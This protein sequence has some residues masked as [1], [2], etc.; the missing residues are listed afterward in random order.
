MSY[1]RLIVSWDGH[2]EVNNGTDYSAIFID[3]NSLDGLTSQSV[4]AGR[5]GNT[6]LHVRVQPDGLTF[7]V[8]I[9]LEGGLTQVKLDQLKAWFNPKRGERW[10]VAQ[11]QYGSGASERILCACNSLRAQ[12]TT[13]FVAEMRA[14][15]G[16]WQ[17]V[18]ADTDSQDVGGGGGEV[19][20]WTLDN[21]GTDD[22][23][24]VVTVTASAAKDDANNYTKRRWI[25]VANRSE[26]ELDDPDSDGYPVMLAD[27]GALTITPGDHV[28]VY[29]GG[30]DLRRWI[31]AS[32]RVWVNLHLRPRKIATLAANIDDTDIA[33]AVNNTEGFDRD[34][35]YDSGFFKIDDETIQYS[36][37][38]RFDAGT[39]TRGARG[40]VAA[41]HT[42]GATIYWVEHDYLYLLYDY[43]TPPDPPL[44]D[45]FEPLIDMDASSNDEHQWA[46]E[47]YNPTG[48]RRSRGWQRR[49]TEAGLADDYVRQYA[50]TGEAV[51]ENAAPAA[52]KPGLNDAVM[53]FLVP[54]AGPLEL[55]QDVG[56][57]MMLRAFVQD[58]EGYET[59]LF[60]QPYTATPLTAD[61]HALADNVRQ[62]RLQGRIA[63][64]VGDLTLDGDVDSRTSNTAPTH[65]F[66]RFEL[67]QQTAVYG[68]LAHHAVS[69]GGTAQVVI[70]RNTTEE[71]LGDVPDI[72]QGLVGL[73]ATLPDTTPDWVIYTLF[74]GIPIFLAAGIYWLRLDDAT[75]YSYR[76]PRA[77]ARSYIGFVNE[78]DPEDLGFTIQPTSNG[79][80]AILSL[81]TDPQTDAPFGAGG[82]VRVAN[83]VAPLDST[84]SPKIDVGAEADVYLVDEEWA[85]NTSQEYLQLFFPLSV[86]EALEIDTERRLI[87]DLETGQL[88]PWARV[89]SSARWPHLEPGVND[90]EW[91]GTGVIGLDVDTTWN[92]LRL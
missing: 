67:D 58:R 73:D 39:L 62:V 49:S 28:R 2:T 44:A 79:I 15:T 72:T 68:V 20:A 76:T 38:G 6:P 5:V 34:N 10:L 57:E 48:S 81:E 31:D 23:P 56:L 78:T 86:G 63:A 51:F 36:G 27:L 70:Y 80:F 47:F 54:L 40:S 92:A 18:T 77:M 11:D 50:E 43:D 69:G 4:E 87:T 74:G 7:M 89:L 65:D 29:N 59:R 64:L 55:D 14:A 83:V 21:D 66:F 32:D 24:M 16:V 17:E 37:R 13:F 91:I 26:E 3:G 19:L 22:T 84:R 60:N 53:R 35:W 25:S 41:A 85:N 75:I 9:S 52:G 88:V 71:F 42:A 1:G 45:D 46:D 90:I 30:L 33:L 8:L 82:D 61:S 12:N